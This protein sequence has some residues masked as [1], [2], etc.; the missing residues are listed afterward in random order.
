[1]WVLYPMEGVELVLLGGFGGVGVEGWRGGVRLVVAGWGG[2][3][4]EGR[5]GW[6]FWILGMR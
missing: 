1:M 5:W 6:L 2:G 3:W 4:F